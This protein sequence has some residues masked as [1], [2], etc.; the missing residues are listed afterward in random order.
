M[1]S[2]DR[3]LIRLVNAGE[4]LFVL[5]LGFALLALLTKGV[6]RARADATAAAADSGLDLRYFW[7]DLVLVAPPVVAFVGLAKS[8]VMRHDLAFFEPA[9]FREMPAVLVL[10]LTVMASDFIGYWRHRLMHCAALWPVHAIHHS[11]RAMTWLALARFHPL[12]RL[13]TTLFNALFLALLGLPAWAI[14]TN[15]SIRHFYGYALH[16]DLPWS[17]GPLRYVF[18]TPLMHRWHH[19]RD[20][21]QAQHNFATIFSVYDRLF[22]TYRVPGPDVP[23]L[24]YADSRL[25]NNWTGQTLYPLRVWYGA[26]RGRWPSGSAAV[27]R[28]PA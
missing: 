15:G 3:L 20:E 1:W 18:V 17:G 22:G 16:A 10:L 4:E 8:L 19:V 2:I 27:S 26:L 25:P 11:P 13:I 5:A 21:S 7:L 9:L 6:R 24:G 14:L 12:N 23:E 28:P